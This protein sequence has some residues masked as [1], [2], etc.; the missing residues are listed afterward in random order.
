MFELSGIGL[1]DFLRSSINGVSAFRILEQQVSLQRDMLRD[2]RDI[3]VFEFAEG[4]FSAS[5][6]IHVFG[7]W[8]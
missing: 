2:C 3:G 1:T 7:G 4:T 6:R 8:R 5:S